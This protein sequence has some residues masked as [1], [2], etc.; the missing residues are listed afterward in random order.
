MALMK[1]GENVAKGLLPLV[2]GFAVITGCGSLEPRRCPKAL[3]GIAGRRGAGVLPQAA[4][5]EWGGD[6]PVVSARITA[7]KVACYSVQLERGGVSRYTYR[8]AATARI[9]RTIADSARF[10]E[11][12]RSL[13]GGFDDDV[14]FQ[15]VSEDGVVLAETEETA[16]ITRP[17]EELVLTA[18]FIDLSLDQ[19]RQAETVQAFWTYGK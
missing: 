18:K 8:V 16:K 7:V 13:F 17:D 9:T 3:T 14:R 19:V 4:G 15:L 11:R 1:L 12:E 6:S 5:I 10:A 2:V